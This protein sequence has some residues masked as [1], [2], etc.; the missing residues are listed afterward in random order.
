MQHQSSNT[1]FDVPS[2]QLHLSVEANPMPCC[3]TLGILLL[4]EGCP[5]LL[6]HDPSK[7]L[8]QLVDFCL[9]NRP[10]ESFIDRRLFA[11]RLKKFTFR[12][13]RWMPQLTAAEYC[14]VETYA[15]DMCRCQLLVGLSFGLNANCLMCI[16]H[17]LVVRQDLEDA[18]QDFAA[19][20]T[21]DVPATD[22]KEDTC[23]ADRCTGIGGLP[24]DIC[25]WEIVRPSKEVS[26]HFASN[27]SPAGTPVQWCPQLGHMPNIQE[28]L[29]T[30][31]W[32]TI[33]WKGQMFHTERQVP[34][35]LLHLDGPAM[36]GTDK[37]LRAP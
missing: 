20:L 26:N 29:N 36:P 19:I 32:S 30:E 16:L 24:A 2:R 25:T 5:C 1:H 6:F 37:V 22:L 23:Q 18:F 17:D 31:S 13:E 3:C 28:Q 21:I 4:A 15:L 14:R 34:Q 10:V 9:P 35:G 7:A 27:A 12:Q 8:W 33:S 11:P